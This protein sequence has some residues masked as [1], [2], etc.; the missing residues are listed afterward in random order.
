MR[1]S[2]LPSKTQFPV[3]QLLKRI[4][5][6][7]GD[8]KAEFTWSRAVKFMKDHCILKIILK[9]LVPAPAHKS[10]L[11]YNFFAE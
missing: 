1:K 10:G 11:K 2:G 8:R 3:A 5:S 7:N 9:G 4:F 6:Q